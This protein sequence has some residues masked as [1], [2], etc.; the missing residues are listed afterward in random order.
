MGK[1]TEIRINGI[2][3]EETDNDTNEIDENVK[4]VYEEERRSHKI[5]K[6]PCKLKNSEKKERK[7][8]VR[9][10]SRE[11]IREEYGFMAVENKSIPYEILNILY[12]SNAPLTV[13]DIIRKLGMPNHYRKRIAP[14]VSALSRYLG[15][16]D[17]I[18]KTRN[19]DGTCNYVLGISI[20]SQKSLDDIYELLKKEKRNKQKKKKGKKTK[21][22]FHGGRVIPPEKPEEKKD[23]YV[24]PPQESENLTDSIKELASAIRGLSTITVNINFNK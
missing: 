14:E 18:Q 9:Q 1:V 22:T 3:I 10:L 12:Q 20:A 5:Y 7:N 23:P 21:P 11:E 13:D 2:P 24:S 15:E 8:P 19:S 16:Y 6:R 4:E 17:I